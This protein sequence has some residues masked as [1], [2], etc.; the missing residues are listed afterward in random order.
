M[1]LA[2]FFSPLSLPLVLSSLLGLFCALQLF[3]LGD[4]VRE[5]A[6]STEDVAALTGDRFSRDLETEIAGAEGQEGFAVEAGSRRCPGGFGEGSFV[7][8]EDRSRCVSLA[9]TTVRS[10]SHRTG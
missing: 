10:P 4:E 3:L 6:F 5:C 2:F 9:Y 7:G 8:G 1:L